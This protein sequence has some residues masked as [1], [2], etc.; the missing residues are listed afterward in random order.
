M[1]DDDHKDHEG[2]RELATSAQGVPDGSFDAAGDFEEGDQ[3]GDT[4]YIVRNRIGR[5]GHATVY[6]CENSIGRVVAVKVIRRDLAK[7]PAL[8]EGM[9]AEAR[10]HVVLRHPNV[11]EVYRAGVS[12]GRR[13]LAYIEMERLKGGNGRQ[14]LV[15]KENLR[16]PHALDII[17]DV[18]D[19]LALAHSKGIVHQDLKP[20]NIFIHFDDDIGKAVTKLLDFGIARIIG[21]AYNQS[22]EGTL[23]YAAPE[24]LEGTTVSPLSDLYALGIVLFEFLTGH[25]PFEEAEEADKREQDSHQDSIAAGRADELTYCHHLVSAKTDRPAPR[26]RDVVESDHIPRELDHLVAALLERE[27]ANRIL[28]EE[29]KRAAEATAALDQDRQSG[30]LSKLSAD[31]IKKREGNAAPC[32]VTAGEL[33]K[34]LRE[35]R[36]KPGLKSNLT[37]Q[38]LLIAKFRPQSPGFVAQPNAELSLLGSRASAP[39]PLLAERPRA[40]AAEYEVMPQDRAAVSALP[41]LPARGGPAAP[42]PAPEVAPPRPGSNDK[43]QTQRM[44][45]VPPRASSG[46]PIG[47]P[48]PRVRTPEPL[49]PSPILTVAPEDSARAVEDTHAPKDNAA[50]VLDEAPF[51]TSGDPLPAASTLEGPLFVPAEELARTADRP[52]FTPPRRSDPMGY[53]PEPVRTN[54]IGVAPPARERLMHTPPRATPPSHGY[55][56]GPTAPGKTVGTFEPVID[57]TGRT[58]VAAPRVIEDPGPEPEPEPAYEPPPRISSVARRIA[59]ASIAAS[60]GLVVAGAGVTVARHMHASAALTPPEGATAPAA[61][62]SPTQAAARDDAP[63]PSAST[64]PPLTPSA[65][66]SAASSA[67]PLSAP[68]PA[69]AAP[70]PHRPS[71][72]PHAPAN[73]ATTSPLVQDY[74]GASSASTSPAVKPPPKAAP[75]ASAHDDIDDWLVKPKKK[76]VPGPGF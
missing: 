54:P 52:V 11:V 4:E 49:R 47:T 56:A 62:T 43:G 64:S 57:R 40:S 68:N 23:A 55:D 72:K 22:F 5:G 16:V 63:R 66:A 19:A 17:I 60:I 50:T 6:E 30:V 41:E 44:N 42:S 8:L 74:D 65:V 75:S 31:E 24:Q 21:Q 38:Q 71:S 36:R 14:L 33:A 1:R 32:P 48:D 18:C 61:A 13:P 34:R 70:P 45:I 39:E 59:F 29:R 76:T 58:R 46:F 26:I 37:T 10:R 2:L 3:I 73:A 7:N 67:A 20:D 53:A 15:K 25:R 28:P 69:S 12:R 35:I 27:P 51:R 9:V